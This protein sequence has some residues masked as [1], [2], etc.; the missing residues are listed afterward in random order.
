MKESTGLFDSLRAG[1]G[2][3]PLATFRF[4]C[5]AALLS[6]CLL[7]GNGARAAEFPEPVDQN[8]QGLDWT[9]VSQTATTLPETRGRPSPELPPVQP[10]PPPAPTLTLPTSPP[11]ETPMPLGQGPRFVLRDVDITGNT[12]LDQAAIRGVVDPYIGKLVTTADLE[13][14]RRQFT[15][16]YINRGYINSGAVIPDQ[17]V[18]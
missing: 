2:H 8:D 18:V 15:L 7:S 17:N 13:E 4:S 14:I 11:S 12:V 3:S 5:Y 6:A 1:D 16:L 9:N 10:S